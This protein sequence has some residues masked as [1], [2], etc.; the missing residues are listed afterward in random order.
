MLALLLDDDN[1]AGQYL[2]DLW[3]NVK[4]AIR[5]KTYHS[6]DALSCMPKQT[7]LTSRG[8]MRLHDQLLA[9]EQQ[10]IKNFGWT[11]RTE[12]S[13]PNEQT[14]AANINQQLLSTSPN[15][16]TWYS[17][18][19]I[20]IIIPKDHILLPGF[21]T[22]LVARSYS[23]MA[24]I[25]VSG[26]RVQTLD[27]EVPIQVVHPCPPQMEEA[28]T[29]STARLPC[30]DTAKLLERNLDQVRLLFPSQSF[31]IRSLCL[32]IDGIG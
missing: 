14:P 23:L 16:L 11:L 1:T 17:T 5:I 15:T 21:C 26:A 25:S 7:L 30:F 2:K 12:A 32:T 24:R 18:V 31:D 28:S 8:P 20:P 10:V 29:T 6:A 22:T 27:F 9:L 19:V 4:A 3:L 13:K